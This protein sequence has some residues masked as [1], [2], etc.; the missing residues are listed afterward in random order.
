[1]KSA[2]AMELGEGEQ[3]ARRR[4]TLKVVPRDPAVAQLARWNARLAAE[5]MPE[6]LPFVRVEWLTGEHLVAEVRIRAEINGTVF[7]QLQTYFST[8]NWRRYPSRER[9]VFQLYAFDGL[10]FDEIDRMLGM[11]R[12]A[13]YIIGRHR[14][15][16]GVKVYNCKTGRYREG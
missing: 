7:D 11:I 12:A 5:G 3:E 15:R 1:M 14:A 16:A 2:V 4:P 13:E 10:S 8:T 6:E 9:R